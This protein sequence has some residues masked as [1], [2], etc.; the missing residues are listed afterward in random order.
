MI[1]EERLRLAIE[2][3]RSGNYVQGMN[4]LRMDLGEDGYQHC[5]LGVLTEVALAQGHITVEDLPDGEFWG[6]L[7]VLPYV[8][9]KWYGLNCADPFLGPEPGTVIAESRVGLTATEANDDAGWDFKEIADAFER[10]IETGE[11]D[12]TGVPNLGP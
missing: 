2:A 8:V 3:L 9:W 10:L 4:Q 5:C 11:G 6:H 7:A 12:G 1:N